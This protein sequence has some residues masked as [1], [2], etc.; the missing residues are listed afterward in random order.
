MLKHRKQRSADD[1]C[2]GFNGVNTLAQPRFNSV[3]TLCQQSVALRQLK[4]E[5]NQC[6]KKCWLQHCC[7]FY[8]VWS[9]YVYNNVV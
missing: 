6:K 9:G 2:P 3:E 4:I 1:T 8:I 5:E 7:Q